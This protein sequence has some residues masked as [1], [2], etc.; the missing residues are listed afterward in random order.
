MTGQ[1][2]RGREDYSNRRRTW[3]L[4]CVI[5]VCAIALL[6]RGVI[7]YQIYPLKF[8]DEIKKYS[9]EYTQDPYFV[10]AVI[11]TESGF[12]EKAES[13]PGAV[14]LMQIMPDTGVWAAEKMGITG[15]SVDMLNQPDMNI[16]IGCW[17]L[18]YLDDMFGGDKDKVMAAYNAGP[19]NV[20][21]WAG[22][23]KL[24]DIPFAET[25]NYLEK[26]TRNLQIYKGL[27]DEF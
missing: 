20:I 5:L 6:L 1:R 10:S 7:I 4:I 14:G 26:V 23:E 18:K 15:F 21:E 25:K 9:A 24:T 27:Y 22:D 2:R 17:Y 8:V 19:N 3:T 13:G 12:D 11:C 16:R